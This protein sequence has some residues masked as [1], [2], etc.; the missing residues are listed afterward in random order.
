MTL[1]LIIL[2]GS[3]AVLAVWCVCMHCTIKEIVDVL[4]A[5][6]DVHREMANAVRDLDARIVAMAP[7]KR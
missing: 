5:A 3:T 7:P 2:G 1:A 4:G 6:R